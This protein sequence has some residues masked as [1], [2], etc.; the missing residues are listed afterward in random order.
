[1]HIGDVYGQVLLV[2][3]A[4]LAGITTK[5]FFLQNIVHKLGHYLQM[6]ITVQDNVTLL[7]I[8]RFI[9]VSEFSI[10]DIFN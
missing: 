1:M 6:N 7:Y 10:F 4:V 5:L 9:N 8:Y 2:A 3:V